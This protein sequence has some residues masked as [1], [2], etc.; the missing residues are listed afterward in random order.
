[1]V[2][3]AFRHCQSAICP[4][5]GCDLQ[6]KKDWIRSQYLNSACAASA[7]PRGVNW[8]GHTLRQFKSHVYILLVSTHIVHSKVVHRIHYNNNNANSAFSQLLAVS[9]VTEPVCV[10][11][12]DCDDN[13]HFV[14]QGNQG[15]CVCDPGYTG[16]GF[17]CEGTYRLYHEVEVSM[18]F[19]HRRP[20]V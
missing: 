3:V 8:A 17:L 4:N 18:W 15:T 6:V 19:I 20:K 2:Q 16:D 5:L 10:H 14:Q 7:L 12:D 9:T 11:P 1:M 13:A